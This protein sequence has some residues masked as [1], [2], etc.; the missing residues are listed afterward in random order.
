MIVDLQGQIERIA[1]I[2]SSHKMSSFHSSPKSQF[3]YSVAD[4]NAEKG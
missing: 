4:L 2:L 3:V 1:H